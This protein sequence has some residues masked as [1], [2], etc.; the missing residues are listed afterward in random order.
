MHREKRN[1]VK[2]YLLT[3]ECGTLH[4][5]HSSQ[6]RRHHI[7]FEYIF[8]NV[9]NIFPFLIIIYFFS[10]DLKRNETKIKVI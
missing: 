8:T 5:A 2:Y 1:C 6:H 3:I 10:I 7:C 9:I 4:T